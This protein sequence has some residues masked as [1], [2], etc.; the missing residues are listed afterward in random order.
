MILHHPK[1]A[2]SVNI[3]AKGLAISSNNL[4]IIAAPVL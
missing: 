1:K 3:V 4:L 2:A